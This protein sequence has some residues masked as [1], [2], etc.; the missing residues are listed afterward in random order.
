MV[1][2]ERN[3]VADQAIDE[4]GGQQEPEDADPDAEPFLFVQAL[5]EIDDLFQHG[6]NPPVYIR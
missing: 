5:E 2:E 6:V 4:V 1:P 3:D